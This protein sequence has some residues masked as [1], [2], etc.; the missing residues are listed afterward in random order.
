MVFLEKTELMFFSTL[1]ASFLISSS[2]DEL[3]LALNFA[4]LFHDFS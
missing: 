2:D 3:V 4:S 1:G